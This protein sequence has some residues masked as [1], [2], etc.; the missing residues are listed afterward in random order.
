MDARTGE[1]RRRPARRDPLLFPR[2]RAITTFCNI[3]TQVQARVKG[4]KEERGRVRERRG[5]VANARQRLWNLISSPK[6]Q[7]PCSLLPVGS[8]LLLYSLRPPGILPHLTLLPPLS[9][10]AIWLTL[11]VRI[12]KFF[13]EGCKRG[14]RRSKHHKSTSVECRGPSS[15]TER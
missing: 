15:H 9:A 8:Q 13:H 7:L 3:V 14:M 5:L 2:G 6:P 12:A 4:G 11:R 1:E 10:S